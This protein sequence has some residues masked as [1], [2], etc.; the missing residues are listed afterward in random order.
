[1]DLPW[2]VPNLTYGSLKTAGRCDMEEE[3]SDYLL[4]PKLHWYLDSPAGSNH[5]EF[6]KITMP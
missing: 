4:H 5:K 2:S 1:M 3:M 6:S